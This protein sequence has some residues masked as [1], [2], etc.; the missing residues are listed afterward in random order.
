MS[1]FVKKT[2]GRPRV[3]IVGGGFAGL[4]AARKLSR[5][6]VEVVLVDRRNHHLFQPLLYQVATAVLSPAD[7]AH[8]IRRIFRHQANTQVVLAEAQ[9]VDPERRVLET[10]VADLEYDYLVL[11]AGSTHSYFGNDWSDRAP[12]LKSIDDALEMRRR[13]LLAFEAAEL[14]DDPAERAAALTFVVVGGGP[15]G[16][17]LAGAL[18]EIAVESIRPDFRRVDTS[19]ARILLVEGAGRLL[20]GMED[21]SSQRALEDLRQMGV[22]VRL[23]TFVTGITDRGVQLGDDELLPARNVLWAAGVEAVPLAG[24]VGADQDKAGRILV[25]ADLS[26]PGHPEVFVVGDLAS[27]KDPETGEPVPGLAPA[28]MQMG[29]YVGR[30]IHEEVAGGRAANRRKPFRY[31]DKGTMATIGRARAVAEIGGARFGGLFAWL[32]WSV[33]HI[34]FLIDFRNRLFVLLS[35]IWSYLLFSKGARLITGGALAHV[36]APGELRDRTEASKDDG[37][38]STSREVHA[39]DSNSSV[40]APS[41]PAIG[42][43]DA[44]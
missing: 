33:V 5:T 39:V 40:I 10:D 25:D 22:E 21:S 37:D 26:V 7:I 29:K 16:V 3:V 27:A 30:R 34:A 2:P 12:G 19:E 28:A 36:Y 43:A 42:Y 23:E 18:R 14:E 31:L 20:P 4:S 32:L 8:P 6:P 13:V 41:R 11:A 17:E 15:T 24:T 44:E 1:T 38:G 35:W 9:R